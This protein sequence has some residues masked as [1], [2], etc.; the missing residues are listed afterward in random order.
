MIRPRQ[1]KLPG[2]RR[3]GAALVEMAIVLPLIMLFF[4]G[5]LEIGRVLMLQHTADAAAYEAARSAMV[6]G[7]TAAE[8]RQ[9]AQQL[10]D[11]AGLASVVIEVTPETITELTPL[12]TVKVDIPVNENSWIAP[13]NVAVLAVSSEVTLMCERPPVTRLAAVDDLN[14]KKQSMQS[15]SPSDSQTTTA[16]SM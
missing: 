3:R 5:L 7:A 14:A 9:V 1:S 15:P 8:A 2:R 10:V 13:R 4:T 11:A 12:I 6:P 16:D